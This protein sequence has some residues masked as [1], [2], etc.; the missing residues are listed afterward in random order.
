MLVL[1]RFTGQEIIIGEGK[2]VIRIKLLSTEKGKASI[3]IDA[4]RN[5][6]VHR[7]EIYEKIHGVH[8]K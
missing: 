1:T 2:D 8:G 7:K 6:E 5:I 3:G 4:P